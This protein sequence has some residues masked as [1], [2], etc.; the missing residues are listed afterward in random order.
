MLSVIK[1]CNV[2][3][4][5]VLMSVIELCNVIP[6]VVML[7]VVGCYYDDENAAKTQVLM[8]LCKTIGDL[9]LTFL[10]VFCILVK[11]CFFK[12]FTEKMVQSHLAENILTD[13]HLIAAFHC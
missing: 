7:S 10:S 1:L 11:K 9:L 13:R 5:V 4:N 2:I 8:H 12:S 3:P 6:N